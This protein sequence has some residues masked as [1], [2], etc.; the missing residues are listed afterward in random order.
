MNGEEFGS[1]ACRS[2]WSTGKIRQRMMIDEALKRRD[3]WR[4]P[5][6]L[7]STNGEVTYRCAVNEVERSLFLQ[8]DAIHA[9]GMPHVFVSR[10]RCDVPLPERVATTDLFYDVAREAEARGATMFMLGAVKSPTAW[11]RNSSR[12]NSPRSSSS[13]DGTWILRER[14]RG[15]HCLRSNSN[16]GARRSLDLDGR[17]ARAGIHCPASAS[18]DVGRHY[19]DVRWAVRFSVRLQAAG[20]CVDAECRARMALAG[21]A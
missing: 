7:T 21:L 14:G 20:T 5:A 4:Y 16:A 8:A 2:W 9:D 17:A 11:P 18:P 6:Y 13:A 3:L 12:I 19:Q 10:I 15:D 1:A